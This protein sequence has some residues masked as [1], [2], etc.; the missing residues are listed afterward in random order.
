MSRGKSRRA[1]IDRGFTTGDA[2]IKHRKL[3]PSTDE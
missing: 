2:R 3:Y 1:G